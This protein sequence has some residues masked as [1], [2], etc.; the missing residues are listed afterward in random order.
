MQP[1]QFHQLPMFVQAETLKD[2][3]Q[4]IP[5]DFHQYAYHAADWHDRALESNWKVKLQDGLGK[6]RLGKHIDEAGGVEEPVLLTQDRH[7]GERP[8]LTD[9]HHRTAV[10][11]HRNP[12]SWV[13]VRH[14]VRG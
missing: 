8:E 13:P 2:V 9:G 4:T 14:Q 5:G 7:V 10:A 3:D 6:K 12:K 1:R 11:H